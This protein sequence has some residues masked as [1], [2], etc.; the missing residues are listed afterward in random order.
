MTLDDLKRTKRT[1]MEKKSFCGAHQK[2][3]NE[4]RPTLSAAKCRSM[5]LVRIFV[6]IPYRE[7]SPNDSRI[8]ESLDAQTFPSRRW[9]ISF[10]ISDAQSHISIQ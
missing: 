7:G 9:D 10:E 4:D 5:I 1:L 2:I 6:G 3:L 8:I